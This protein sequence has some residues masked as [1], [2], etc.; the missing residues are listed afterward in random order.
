[1]YIAGIVKIVIDYLTA[2]FIF[3]RLAVVD[4]LSQI[5]V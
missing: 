4:D 2:I 1:M 5:I 3:T